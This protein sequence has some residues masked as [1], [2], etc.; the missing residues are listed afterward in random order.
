VWR[1]V[2]GFLQKTASKLKEN[3]K[4]SLTVVILFLALGATFA[5]YQYYNQS[6][7]DNQVE[8][9]PEVEQNYSTSGKD[10]SPTNPAASPRPSKAAD[11]QEQ[12]SGAN[13]EEVEE[14]SS[15]GA[16][17]VAAQTENLLT[18]LAKPAQGEIISTSEWYKDELLDAWKYNPGMDIK[19]AVG[20]EVRAAHQGI[21]EEIIKDDFAGTTVTLKHNEELKTKYIN[22]QD[23]QFKEGTRVEK[24]QVIGKVGDSGSSQ[25]NRLRF[26]IIEAGEYKPPADY[27]N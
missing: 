7:P 3:W 8:K 12:T 11:S 16:I 6:I 25:N 1:K 14:D 17:K 19:A 24:G 2:K 18:N 21:I 27:I 10:E 26:E 5:F 9:A 23:C 15:Q 20:T 13:A 4:R 22:L